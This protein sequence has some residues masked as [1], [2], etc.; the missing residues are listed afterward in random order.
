MLIFGLPVRVDMH[1][2]L[3]LVEKKLK[4]EKAEMKRKGVRYLGEE[5]ALEKYR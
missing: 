2:E 4:R 3:E 5:E 1:S